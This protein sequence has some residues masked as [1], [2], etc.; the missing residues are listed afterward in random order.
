MG[1]EKE[2]ERKELIKL[3]G[4]REDEKRDKS[5]GQKTSISSASDSLVEIAFT[6]H[7]SQTLL[8]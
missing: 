4:A 6:V 1:E 7:P 2:Y 5:P 3:G 8:L